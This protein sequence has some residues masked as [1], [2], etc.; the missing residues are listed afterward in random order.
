MSDPLGLVNSL[1]RLNPAGTQPGIARPK[2]P[3]AAEFRD[4]LMRQIGEVNKL[5]QEASGAAQDVMTGR[6]SDFEGVMIAT[7]K[8][9]TAFKMLLAVRN[10]VMD[11]YDE[12]KQMRV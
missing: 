3:N 6:R 8:A 1:H 12:V 7:Q 10:K 2:D 9:D 11:A 4:E 5:Q